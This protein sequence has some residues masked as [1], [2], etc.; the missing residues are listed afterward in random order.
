[1]KTTPKNSESEKP[2]LHTHGKVALGLLV[3]LTLCLAG[4]SAYSESTESA[5]VTRPATTKKVAK[6]PAKN[7]PQT[8]KVKLED[9]IHRAAGYIMDNTNDVGRLSYQRHISPYVMMDPKKYNILRHSGTIY[10]T[11]LY[12]QAY[13]G[14]K[15]H[16][17]RIRLTKY[18]VENYVR[19]IEGGM[20][21]VVS[22]PEEE[23][24]PEPQGKLGAAGL[25]L[26]GISDLCREGVL[27]MK[28][29]RGL[30]DFILFLQKPDGSFF[31]K[32]IYSTGKK[33]DEFMSIYY[34]GEAAL[35]LLYL[36]DA[37]P[38][39]KWVT[40]A[41]RALLYLA[42]LRAGKKATEFDHWAMLAT[43]KLLALPENG[44]TPDERER[45]L[46]HARQMAD[47]VF[48]TQILDSGSPHF[49]SVGGNISPCSNG[50]KM[51]GLLAIY[52]VLGTS[53]PAFRIRLLETLDRLALFLARA[54]ITD[55]Y[56]CGGFPSSADWRLSG[57]PK[58]SYVVRIDNVQHIMSAWINYQKLER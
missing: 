23:G 38:Q 40:G 43:D 46:V 32:Y 50:T 19:E 8:R 45:L 57:L 16:E 36:N 33:S 2:A 25:S 14:T 55:E 51:E 54:Q 53:D 17:T 9:G 12:D 58:K 44:V 49:G 42:D 48:P 11:Y 27:D 20:Y 24:I 13:P 47:F 18:L 21:T 26:L 37:D 41:K 6:T 4:I 10:S 35:G 52:H 7:V 28:I 15:M 5:P 30:G 31:C 1:M 22:T 3:V 29:C 39:E 34:P 56:L